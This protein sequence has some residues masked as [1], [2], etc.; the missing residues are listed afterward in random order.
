VKPRN[1]PAKEGGDENTVSDL[2]LLREPHQSGRL[3]R[4]SGFVATHVAQTNHLAAILIHV[5]VCEH[6]QLARAQ[7][8][9]GERTHVRW[10]SLETTL[11]GELA[12]AR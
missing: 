12:I 7:L 1:T 4:V 3:V 10:C 5:L 8:I 11:P 9:L 6:D 2:A